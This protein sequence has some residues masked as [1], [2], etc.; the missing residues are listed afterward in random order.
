MKSSVN[1][2]AF[3]GNYLPRQCGIA[4]FTTDIAE[5]VASRFP[6]A[7]VFAIPMNDVETGYDYPPRV[8][9]EVAERELEAYRR[10]AD[11]LNV[12]D[13]DVV[14]LQHEYGIFGGQAGSHILTL[15]RDLRMPVVTTLHTVLRDPEPAYR[16]VMDE[17]AEL[18]DRLIVMSRRGHEFLLD[19]YGIPKEKIDFVH[20]GIPDVPFVDPN[21]HKDKF[22]V[23]GK[24]VVLT[25]G[26]LSPNKGIENVINALPSIL[27]KHPD[28][29]YM[30]LGATHPHLKREQGESYRLSLQRLVEARGVE[31]NVVFHNRFVSLEELVEYIG[32]AD[33]YVTPYLNPAQIVSGT[34]A[35]SV[36]AGKPV[37]STPY[38]YAEELLADGRGILVP[39]KDPNAIA[40]KVN[41]LLDNEAERHAIR[42]RAYALGRDMIWDRV[43]EKYM[44]SFERAR[45]ERFK[46]PRGV[47]LARTADKRPA[48]L[49]LLNLDHLRRMT[50]ETGI[51]QHATF[52]VPNYAEG[53]T[54]DDNARALVLAVLLEELGDSTAAEARRMAARYLAFIYHAFEAPT[55]RFSDS[56]TYDRRWLDPVGSEDAHGRA[57][58]ALGTVAGRSK[59]EG[60]RGL[61]GRLFDE[62]LP[63]AEAMTSPRAWAFALIGIMEFM[64]R[65]FGHRTAADIRLDL[66]ERLLDMYQN[67]RSDDDKWLWFED[68][69]SYDN[70][71]LPH[72]L[73][74]CGQWLD[75]GDMSGAGLD[76]LKWLMDVQRME[77]GYFVPIGT[78]G[79]YPRDGHR[80]RFDQQPIEAHAS[81]SAC[82]E[83]YRMT[84]E[85]KWR[86]E[87]ERVFDWFLG[88]NDLG[89][90]LYSSGTGGCY[91][92][93][94]RD[95]VNQNQ[96][97][98]ATVSYL[99]SRM[100]MEFAEHL[101]VDSKPDD[102]AS[103]E[104]GDEGL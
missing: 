54:V 85:P 46:Q 26:L 98:E 42:R 86:K 50:D 75:R 62:A 61:A 29:V 5:G 15:L 36:G 28:V 7:N 6:K 20:H 27:E 17:L 32:A 21:F 80:S 68:V 70:A 33:I 91:D 76:S 79:F 3:I 9:F 71:K 1:G 63:T 67:H 72:A 88:G 73:I 89:I 97:A 77:H 52:S 49:P 14:S 94:S 101:I 81:L 2:I 58:W 102:P 100:E 35:Y 96:G 22:G 13:V 48:A 19:I 65:F 51:L 84:Q 47:F 103:E 66:A 69:L 41:Y 37:V 31:S 12:N 34:L 24:A 38:W 78:R 11:F 39:F 74:L 59:A 10:A 53:Y 95:R 40:D 104:S 90:P 8:R 30:C 64:R 55:G 23:A 25:F 93:V 87:A 18:S 83:A 56:F 43:A 45:E 16:K 44:E 60:L 82:L 4:T 99:L 92:G 57:L